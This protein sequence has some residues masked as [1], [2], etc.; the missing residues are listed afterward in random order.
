MKTTRQDDDFKPTIDLSEKDIKR[1]HESGLYS[2]DEYE[3]KAVTF[4]NPM[5]GFYNYFKVKELLEKKYGVKI[6]EDQMGK[7]LSV[8]LK[9]MTMQKSK[10]GY[11]Y[12]NIKM[13]NLN[14]KGRK[15]PL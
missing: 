3:D 12:H 8:V 15:N 1:L 5:P 11:G 7:I 4:Q 10:K 14:E 13:K 2:L 6:T 9:D